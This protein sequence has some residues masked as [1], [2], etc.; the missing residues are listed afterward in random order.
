[1]AGYFGV[2]VCKYRE[3]TDLDWTQDQSDPSWDFLLGRLI[4][5]VFDYKYHQTSNLGFKSELNSQD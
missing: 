5:L 3:N 4:K 2:N 1:M